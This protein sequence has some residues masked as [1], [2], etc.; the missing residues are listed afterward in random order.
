MNRSSGILIGGEHFLDPR[1]L[2][3]STPAVGEAAGLHGFSLRQASVHQT[4]SLLDY[5]Q[6]PLKFHEFF[7]SGRDALYSLVASIYCERIWL[8]DFLCEAIY[9]PLTKLNKPI[10][11]YKIKKDFSA[12]LNSLKKVSYKDLLIV[13]HYFGYFDERLLGYASDKYI[14][15]IAD[16]THSLLCPEV[17]AIAP[18]LYG[19]VFA[20]LRKI[21]P[22][23]DLAFVGSREDNLPKPMEMTR[24]R[25]WAL[26]AGALL[27][28]NL[29][30]RNGFSN[31]ENLAPFHMAETVLNGAENFGYK[32]SSLSL[33]VL[34]NCDFEIFFRKAK[35]NFR[36]LFDNLQKD[37]QLKKW[38]DNRFFS[39]YFPVFFPDREKRD[40][41]RAV[42]REARILCPVHWE[43]RFLKKEHPISKQ[44]LS[45]PCDYRYNKSD[46]DF[47]IQKFKELCRCLNE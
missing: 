43:T 31:D 9:Q 26:R 21:G 24:D 17:Y 1:M 34:R 27:S 6:K 7:A 33:D 4:Q 29:S 3:R 16:L 25:F 14:Q 37:G 39:Q 28:R 45:I 46:L 11:F 38:P 12:D 15:T 2:S 19:H 22:F 13:I 40:N 23:P 18:H 10:S 41:F 20:S 44:I 47:L 36:Y 32:A 8:P 42:L 35:E 30:S 5:I